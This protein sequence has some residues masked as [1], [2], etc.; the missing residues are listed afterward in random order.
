MTASASS[1]ADSQYSLHKMLGVW[2]AAAVPMAILRRIEMM[3]QNRSPRPTDASKQAAQTEEER[4][5][6]HNEHACKRF[7]K[8]G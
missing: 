3:P 1:Q 6:H 2:A 8:G 5:K 4:R 7:S